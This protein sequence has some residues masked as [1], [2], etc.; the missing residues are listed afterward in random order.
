MLPLNVPVTVGFNRRFD[1]SHQQLRRQLEQ[2][3][4]GR[5]ELVQMVCADHLHQFDPADQPLLQ[6]AAELLMA[7]IEAPVKA[8]SDRHV[9]GEHPLHHLTGARQG[10]VDRFFASWKPPPGRA[11]RS[12]AKNRSTSPWRAPVR[13][14]SGCSP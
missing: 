5:V 8:D 10:E 12:I 3:L 14:W 7:A 6:L 11:R 2:G 9:Q 13:W 4:I 1:S